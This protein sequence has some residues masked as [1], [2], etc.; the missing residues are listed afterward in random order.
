MRELIDTGIVNDIP[1]SAYEQQGNI[2]Q[3]DRCISCK[4]LGL[5]CTQKGR[6]NEYRQC[7][8]CGGDGKKKSPHK[9]R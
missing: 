2:L 8:K 5:V 6:W 7:W 9:K 1:P 4:G 3:E